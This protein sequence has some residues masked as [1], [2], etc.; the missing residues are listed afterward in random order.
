MGKYI[1]FRFQGQS[2]KGQMMG[3]YLTLDR[4]RKEARKME[5][6]SRNSSTSNPISFHVLKDMGM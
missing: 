5:S 6:T 3:S 1:I 4:A 2:R